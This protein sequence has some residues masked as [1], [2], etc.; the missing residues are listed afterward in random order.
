MDDPRK[1]WKFRVDDL[2]DR[3]L[4]DDYTGAYREALTECSTRKAPWFVVPSG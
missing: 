3:D 2:K 1:N 4:W